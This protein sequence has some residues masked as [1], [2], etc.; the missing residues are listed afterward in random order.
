M[1]HAWERRETDTYAFSRNT[2]KEDILGRNRSTW[3]DNIKA[4]IGEVECEGLDWIETESAYVPVTGFCEHGDEP[5]G[6]EEAETF[7][8]SW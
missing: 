8:T 6:C 2:W 1:W 4:D 5:S 7:L 3:E